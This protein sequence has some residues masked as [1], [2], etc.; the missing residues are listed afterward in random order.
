MKASELLAAL[1]IVKPSLGPNDSI[2]PI[3]AC[4][5]F[6]DDIVYAYNDMTATITPFPSGL[7]CGLHGDTLLGIL[8]LAGDEEIQITVAD[9]VALIKQKSG[10]VKVPALGESLFMFN[11]PDEVPVFSMAFSGEVA[12]AMEQCL[13]C[14]QTDNMSQ[15]FNGVT[16]DVSKQHPLT[17]YSSDNSTAMRYVVGDK[18]EKVN[19][20]V[21]V[22]TKAC[23]QMLKLQDDKA[24]FHIG[25]QFGTLEAGPVSF[26]TKLLPHGLENFERVFATHCVGDLS[27]LP[28]GLLQEIARAEILLAR[29]RGHCEI[30]ADGSLYTITASGILGSMRSSIKGAEV[31]G[32]V[33]VDPG[34]VL[35]VAGHCGFMALN[36]KASLVFSGRDVQMDYV[37]SSGAV[38]DPP[39]VAKPKAK[40]GVKPADNFADI[41]D[42]I[43]F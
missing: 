11:P 21:V 29:D 7:T 43:P 20:A 3:M 14:A 6:M 4:F 17:F 24:E 31:S 25:K 19:V 37:V 33:R 38:A 22:P 32:R 40:P 39:P 30:A 15:S 41:E 26:I 16:V 36:D 18:N 2:Y 10:T 9:G 1:N 12:A 34:L 23:E 5:C 35:R 27:P 13:V 8:G 28:P 42:D